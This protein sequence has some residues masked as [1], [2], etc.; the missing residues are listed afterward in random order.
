MAQPSNHQ[1]FRRPM[2]ESERRTVNNVYKNAQK[3]AR[4]L[5]IMALV[6][7]AVGIVTGASTFDLST[8]SG[9]MTIM[10]VLIG[11]SA[12]IVGYNTSRIHKKVADVQNDGYVIVVRG[13]VSRYSG[14]M[15]T[16][17]M[18]VGPL[19]IGENRQ[20]PMQLQ[21]GTVAEVAC[22]PKLK[23]VVSINQAPMEQPMRIMVPA[24]LEFQASTGV[25]SQAYVPMG[26]NA[27]AA[28]GMS[29]CPSCGTPTNGLTF[30]SNCGTKLQ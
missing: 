12:F 23:S 5:G 29:F 18:T 30:C 27:P 24:D 10:I 17:A 16:S 2:T 25:P 1:V 26:Q 22:I 8:P 7:A 19:T 11:F 28:G 6:F 14:K 21:E 15:N 9:M 13:Q 3:T 4:P 20:N